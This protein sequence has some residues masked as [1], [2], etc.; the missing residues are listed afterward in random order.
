[1]GFRNRDVAGVSG[2][3]LVAGEC[4]GGSKIGETGW[5]IREGVVPAEAGEDLVLAG[6]RVI[7]ANV[8]LRVV[9]SF[10]WV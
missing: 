5:K 4:A 2:K 1:M 9:Q 7:E 3:R 8:P 10:Y 6:Q